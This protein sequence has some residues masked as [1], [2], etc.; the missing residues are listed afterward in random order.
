MCAVCQKPHKKGT[1]MGD[2]TFLDGLRK[3]TGKDLDR[4]TAAGLCRF[5]SKAVGRKGDQWCELMELASVKLCCQDYTKRTL[6]LGL[7]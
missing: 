7:C 6:S 3:G 5:K 1:D 2:E 4:E